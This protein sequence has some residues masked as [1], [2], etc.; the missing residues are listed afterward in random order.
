[1]PQVELH[2]FIELL[3]EAVVLVDEKGAVLHFNRAAISLVGVSGPGPA[4]WQLLTDDLQPLPTDPVAEALRSGEP[5]TTRAKLKRPR[6]Q[7]SL[8]SVQV[9]PLTGV[10]ASGALVRFMP[11][12]E[13]H[14]AEE[15]DEYRRYFELSDDLFALASRK[16]KILRVN[17]GASRTLG[18]SAD[19]YLGDHASTLVHPDDL[20]RAVAA[21]KSNQ[22]QRDVIVR[23]RHR[24]GTWRLISWAVQPE[25]SVEFG[26]IVLLRGVDVTE[27]LRQQDQLVTSREQLAEAQ[28]VARIGTIIR[29]LV[30]GHTEASPQLS[31]MLEVPAGEAVVPSALARMSAADRQRTEQALSQ[32]RQGM[33]STIT[34]QVRLS[35]GPRDFRIWARP[36]A[37]ADGRVHHSM[38]VVQD[39]TDE[40]RLSAQLRTAE[41]AVAMGTL[42]AGVAHEINNPLA[43]ILGN[44]GAVKNELRRA[45]AVP[46]LDMVDLQAALSEAIGGAERVRDIVAGLRA[47][48]STDDRTTTQ[49]DVPRVLEAALNL[50]RNETRTR[51][52]V[53]TV[54]DPVPMVR[55]NEA[56]LGQLFLNL[57]LNAAQAIPPGDPEHHELAVRCRLE[58]HSV[59]VEVS[60]T[61][62]GIAPENRSRIFDPFFTTRE[63]GVGTGLGLFVAQGTV[64][65]LGGTI[66]VTPNPGRGTLF[67]VTL[68]VGEEPHEAV[69]AAPVATGRRVLV[70][71]DEPM[72]LRTVKRMLKGHT[73]S[74]ASSGEEALSLLST[75]QF[76]VILCD[77]MMPGLSGAQLYEQLDP[78][79][80]SR[81]V[82]MTG[83]SSSSETQAFLD[84]HAPR[85]VDKPFDA[86]DLERAVSG[87]TPSR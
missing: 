8:V 58:G 30:T 5:S 15:L 39:V 24:D 20:P 9:T 49:V 73:L 31:R 70:I 12:A 36:Q 83:G 1:M 56:R 7:A 29:D 26:D 19:H 52:Q 13:H 67:T 87:L 28:D 68:P 77:M 21:I 41:R 43:F 69:P 72:I 71:D 32:A 60:D 63:P 55:A 44:L 80:R 45:G 11:E 3:P 4:S 62:E 61:G 38:A 65:E 74:T 37:D 34:V 6:G 42:A 85:V 54:L 27:K 16:A 48:T 59:V 40:T 17:E 76:D 86:G 84:R 25:R 47:F 75:G 53:T 10:G 57:V 22:V 79:L 33:A 14:T 50:T 51:A 64:R 2:R 66:R 18:W 82:F 35:E 81:M 23:M 46:G 78:A